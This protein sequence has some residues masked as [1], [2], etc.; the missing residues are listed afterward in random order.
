[1]ATATTPASSRPATT[2]P[3]LAYIDGLRGLAALYVAVHH[4]MAECVDSGYNRA[5]TGRLASHAIVWLYN[6]EVAVQVFIV[7]S[8]YCLMIPVARAGGTLRGG[9]V[10]FARRRAWRI[11]PTYYAALAVCL[12]LPTIVP[13]LRSSDGPLRWRIT[14]P[15]TAPALISHLFL[16]HHLSADWAYR[17]DYPMWS[18]P[19]EW[20]LYAAFALVLVP[21]WRRLG[22]VAFAA[23]TII[24]GLALSDRAGM[25]YETLRLHYLALF[26]LGMAG[27]AVNFGPRGAWSRHVIRWAGPA[28]LAG[29]VAFVVLRRVVPNDE[30]T[31]DLRLA[32][33][34]GL[35]STALLIWATARKESG[36][37]SP[38]I[39]G[40]EHPATAWLGR[41]SYSL[42]LIHAPALALVHLS[43][44]RSGLG[45]IASLWA[46]LIGGV[47]ASL[48]AGWGLWHTVERRA[49]LRMDR[50]RSINRR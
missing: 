29:L 50:R 19:I 21:L 14:Q 42:Y 38:W 48:L 15:V 4:A 47:T 17:V 35:T 45:S 46:V 33:T 27:A 11:L 9:L 36:S 8:G 23:A 18:I 10:E 39:R 49:L 2:R 22:S 25:P 12:L 28:T 31:A 3:H 16:L 20:W 40:L 34:V 7:L 43:V 1:M 30:W 37:S 5:V 24:L 41:T 32:L 44:L 13:A 26:G 6:G